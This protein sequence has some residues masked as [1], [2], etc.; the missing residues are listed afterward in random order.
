MNFIKTEKAPL[1][2]G[3][4][5]QAVEANGFIFVSGQ[6][7]VHPVTK[8]KMNGP[9]EEQAL[10]ALENVKAIVEGA[11]SSLEKIVKTTVYVSDIE[12][13]GKVNEV[14]AKFFGDH[15]PARAIV[16]T[17]DLHYGLLIEIEAVAIR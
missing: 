4:Y 12:Q 3:H 16:P 14:Y 9:I 13:W 2:A 17:R 7:A 15:K 10:L 11:G 1:P 6:L 8:E 5:S